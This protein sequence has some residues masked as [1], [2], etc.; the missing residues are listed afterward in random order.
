MILWRVKMSGLIT[1]WI[2]WASQ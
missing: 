2:C 1:M